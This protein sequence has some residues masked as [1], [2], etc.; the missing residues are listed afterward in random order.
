M[1]NTKKGV[2]HRAPSPLSLFYTLRL[3]LSFPPLSFLP[4]PFFLSPSSY[5]FLFATTVV[6]CPPLLIPLFPSLS[7]TLHHTLRLLLLRLLCGSHRHSFVTSLQRPTHRED[8]SFVLSSCPSEVNSPLPFT[9]SLTHHSLSG[10][11]DTQQTTPDNQAPSKRQADRHTPSFLLLVPLSWQNSCPT[12]PTR[13]LFCAHSHSFP[14]FHSLPRP[15]LLFCHAHRSIILFFPLA[16]SLQP[17]L[18]Y[19]TTINTFLN[20]PVHPPSPF[21]LFRLFFPFTLFLPSLPAATRPRLPA[22]PRTQ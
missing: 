12:S 20:I 16:P 11:T 4:L 2:C 13:P 1:I 14:P 17:Y 6:C 15:L 5:L 10:H 21:S 19:R 8:P 18:P 9:P 22:V 3:Y 7:S